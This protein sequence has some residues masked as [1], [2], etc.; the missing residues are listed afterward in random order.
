M[1]ERETVCFALAHALFLYEK[2]NNLTL[3][4][5]NPGGFFFHPGDLLAPIAERQ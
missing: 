3:P 2:Y 4:L 5:I 1:G